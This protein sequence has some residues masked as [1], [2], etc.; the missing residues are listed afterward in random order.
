MFECDSAS[1]VDNELAN[2]NL[3]Q[4]AKWRGYVIKVNRTT[5]RDATSLVDCGFNI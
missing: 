4:D 1:D 3:Y 2:L 5:F